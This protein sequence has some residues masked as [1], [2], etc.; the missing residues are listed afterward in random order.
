MDRIRELRN[1]KGFSQAKLAV[2]A[3]MDPATL[4]RIEQGKGNPNLKTLEKLAES[5]GV[6]VADLLEE[7]AL[8]GKGEASEEA[9]PSVPDTPGK[10]K[11]R[12][13]I[14]ADMEEAGSP[15]HYLA[16]SQEALLVLFDDVETV[17]E[18]KALAEAIRSER[19]LLKETLPNA[20][21]PGHPTKAI[22]GTL[23][24]AALGIRRVGER[25]AEREMARIRAETEEAAKSL[26]LA[27]IA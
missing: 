2:K 11:A 4:N 3:G 23:A 16:M 9:R 26:E 10:A 27:A 19:Q 25:V 13:A 24:T 5:L 14:G 17:E 6:S 20:T 7:P 22:M 8:L 12:Q 18:A 21:F 15:V 1:R